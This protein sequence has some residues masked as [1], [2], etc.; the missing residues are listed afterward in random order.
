MTP[1]IPFFSLQAFHRGR[2]GIYA[3]PVATVH[4]AAG[5]FAVAALPGSLEPFNSS[6]MK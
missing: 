1:G 2:V 3:R 6:N 4:R 5:G